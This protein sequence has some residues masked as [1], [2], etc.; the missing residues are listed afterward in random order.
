MDSSTVRRLLRRVHPIA[1]LSGVLLVALIMMNAATQNSDRFG[2]LYSIL[3]LINLIGIVLLLV[4]I[5]TNIYKLAAQYREGAVGSRLTLRLF[6]MTVVIAIVPVLVVFFFSLQAINRGIDSWFDVRVEKALD[7]ALLLGRTSLDAI[8]QDLVSKT[9][10]MAA[11]LSGTS[12][13]L[14]AP[15][16]NLLR[17][18]YTLGE[19]SLFDQDGLVIA[20][21]SQE[22]LGADTLLPDSPGEAIRSQIRRGLSYANLDPVA[23]GELQL[24]IVVPVYG[25]EVGTADR[26]LQVLQPL[27][28]RYANLGE[29]VQSAFAEY[30]KLVYLRGPLKFGFTL[31][32]SLVALITILIA[33]WA[34]IFSARRLVRP[35][36]DLAQGTAAVAEGDYRKRLHVPS[37]DE[38]GVLVK[39]FNEMTERIHSAQTEI[40]R[41]QR[42]AEVQRTYLETVLTHLSSGVLSFDTRG[43][44]RT[45]NTVANDILGIDLEPGVGDRLSWIANTD[46][47][48]TA[49][50]EVL[51]EH[52]E[53]GSPEWQSEVVLQDGANRTVLMLRGTRLPGLRGRRG[54]YVLVFD[55]VTTMIQA[56]RDAAW[57]EVARRLAH[58]IKNP[59]TPIQLSAERIRSKCMDSLQDKERETLDRSTRTIVDQVEALKSMVNAFSNYARPPQLQ[60]APVNLNTL[61]R[62]V[63]DMYRGKSGKKLPIDL[64]LDDALPDIKAD[65]GR[66]RQVL[67]NLITNSKDAL[68]DS[69]SPEIKISTRLVGKGEHPYLEFAIEDNGPGFP[70]AMMDRLFEPYATDKEKGSGLGLAI[71]KKI[72]EEHSGSLSAD[73]TGNGARVVIRLP[74]TE[75]SAAPEQHREKRA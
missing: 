22:G 17:E 5:G 32:L 42:E 15:T 61:I 38:L 72:V 75:V 25:R 16:L 57:S 54:G 73:N 50:E 3:L 10:D 28:T 36:R 44:L 70:Q 6:T 67:H 48:L 41:G 30:E 18:Q 31:T 51:R 33:L 13:R 23:G 35:I 52:M 20:S 8:K 9:N 66:L 4:L 45:Y 68:A 19:I 65:S 43:N 29:S 34:S 27:P 24:R 74:L 60:S 56:Q 14:A 39:S 55:D 62:D 40:K 71:V 63:A 12:T 69:E 21:S 47:R 11:E 46:P 49:F 64:E 58:E 2:N 1:L 53:N 37:N 26:I 7:D 59:L